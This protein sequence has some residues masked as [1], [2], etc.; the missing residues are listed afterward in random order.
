MIAKGDGQALCDTGVARNVDAAHGVCDVEIEGKAP[1]EGAL[2]GNSES[3]VMVVPKDGSVVA[4]VWVSKTT[5]VVVMVAEVEEI[6]LMGGQLGG[7][8]KVEELVK[9]LNAVEKDLNSLKQVFL[10]DWVP[11]SQDGGAALKTAAATWAGRR[12]TET[13]KS[14]IENEKVKQ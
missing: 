11:V 10:Q 2:I 6:R 1:A 13:Q 3:G 12:L 14:D 5:A 7:L 8:V 4:V 9:K